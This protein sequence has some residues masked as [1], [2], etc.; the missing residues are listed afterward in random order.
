MVRQGTFREDL[1]FRLAVVCI[2]LP[3]LRERPQD[4]IP[5][6]NHFL[7]A[8]AAFYGEERKTLTRR[9][10]NLLLAYHWP[11]NVRELANIMERAHVLSAGN[12]IRADSFPASIRDAASRTLPPTTLTLA[13]AERGAV[14]QALR[15]ARSVKS[16]AAALLE[17]DP[18]RL[19]RLMVRLGI[20]M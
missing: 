5:L 16:R 2:E 4:I 3:P 7:N 8:L 20:S 19:D 13:E 9:A 6:A 15:S 10:S 18:R 1:Y 17:I 12:A 14:L 11:G